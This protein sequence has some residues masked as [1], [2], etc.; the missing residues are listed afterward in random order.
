[1]TGIALGERREDTE[2]DRMSE[3][4]QALG[5]RVGLAG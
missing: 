5:E 4:A 3:R 2:A 1:M